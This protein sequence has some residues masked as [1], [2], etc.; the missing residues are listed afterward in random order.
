MKNIDETHTSAQYASAT[1][2]QYAGQSR[3]GE[4]YHNDRDVQLRVVSLDL[5]CRELA[6][7]EVGVGLV[8]DSSGHAVD[9][10]TYDAPPIPYSAAAPH[11]EKKA[12]SG[13]WRT[14]GGAR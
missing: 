3:P 13:V 5:A 1:L 4:A 12:D 6:D 7:R 2:A 8:V 14:H 9:V 10:A 11:R